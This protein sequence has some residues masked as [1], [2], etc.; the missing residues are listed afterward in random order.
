[1]KM[2]EFIDSCNS[3]PLDMY[4]FACLGKQLEDDEAL[5]KAAEAFVVACDEFW[6]ALNVVGVEIG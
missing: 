6:H 1:M 5:R 3:A 2:Q 4:E